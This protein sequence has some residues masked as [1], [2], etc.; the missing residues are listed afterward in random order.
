MRQF[1][2]NRVH[3]TPHCLSRAAELFIKDLIESVACLRRAVIIDEQ[4]LPEVFVWYGHSLKPVLVQHQLIHCGGHSCLSLQ[5]QVTVLPWLKWWN[6]MILVR[7]YRLRNNTLI[8]LR[9]N[10]DDTWIIACGQ[11]VIE[12]F[13]KV[14]LG[15][16]LLQNVVDMTDL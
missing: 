8:L 13:G 12:Y 7:W 4:L 14:R 10:L 11:K 5:C 3:R 6:L 1:E 9:L 2:I 16:I 15:P